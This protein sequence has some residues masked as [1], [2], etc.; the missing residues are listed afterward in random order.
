MWPMALAPRS[1]LLLAAACG[2]LLPCNFAPGRVAL[3]SEGATEPFAVGS[4]DEERTYG[5]PPR[6]APAWASCL[7]IDALRRSLA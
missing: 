4:K 5:G 6:S 2:T 7:L 1:F 3:V